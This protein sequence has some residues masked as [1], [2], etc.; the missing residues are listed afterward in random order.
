MKI[1]HQDDLVLQSL[2]YTHNTRN[3]EHIE[4]SK[5]TQ[6]VDAKS[7][8]YMSRKGEWKKQIRRTISL[9]QPLTDDSSMMTYGT[10]ADLWSSWM[11]LT[12]L[13]QKPKSFLTYDMIS[14]IIKSINLPTMM[15]INHIDQNG[16]KATKKL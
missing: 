6:I 7:I 4:I 2:T 13:E 9:S 1:D 15:R 8:D 5:R 12:R 10:F 16:L 14:Q 3:V 11:F